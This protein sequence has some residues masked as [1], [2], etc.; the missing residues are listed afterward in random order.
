VTLARGDDSAATVTGLLTRLRDGDRA[1]FDEVIP[2]VYEELRGVAHR[3][4]VRWTGDHTLDTTALVHEA[5][6]KLAARSGGEYVSRSHFLAAAARA[7]RQILVDHYRSRRRE[8]RGGGAQAVPL[9]SVS[10]VLAAF[11]DPPSSQQQRLLA[12]DESLHRLA[13]ESERH[14]RIVECRYFG[15]MTIEET[16][17][18]L[19]I[20]PATVK[21]GAAVARAWLRRDMDGGPSQ[22]A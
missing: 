13:A 10:E 6:L 3:H 12:L 4:R 9:E 15:G 2:L 17:D 7:I 18:A 19:G 16:A 21:R 14:A 20:S 5:Y 22:N 1:A 8:K 11:P